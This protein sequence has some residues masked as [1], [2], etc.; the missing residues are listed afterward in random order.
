MNI[1]WNAENGKNQNHEANEVQ[2]VDSIFPIEE[3]AS[4]LVDPKVDVSF[5]VDLKPTKAVKGDR[6]KGVEERDLKE[7]IVEKIV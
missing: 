6:I 2:A 5:D 3:E 4:V 7:I 1:D